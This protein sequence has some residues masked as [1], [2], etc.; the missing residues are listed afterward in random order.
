M[1]SANGNYVN[2]SC[3]WDFGNIPPYEIQSLMK[4]NYYPMVEWTD[5][6]Y[7]G[8]GIWY[9]SWNQNRLEFT[10]C[11]LAKVFIIISLFWGIMVIASQAIDQA[12]IFRTCST[13][14][15]FSLMQESAK[16]IWNKELSLT[17]R[18]WHSTGLGS[19]VRSYTHL[20]LNMCGWVVH[21]IPIC[22]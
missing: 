20:L 11:C 12:A 13:Q 10:Q 14:R 8:T 1:P 4:Y 3:E 15:L 22:C 17:S 18:P 9:V 16:W 5:I 2:F 6:I 19:H 7:V 21:S